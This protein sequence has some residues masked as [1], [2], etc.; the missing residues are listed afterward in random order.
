MVDAC[1]VERDV[2]ETSDDVFD[3]VTGTYTP[4]VGDVAV[5][6]SGKCFVHP[7]SRVEEIRPEGA[8][9]QYRTDYQ[10]RLP[11]TAIGVLP[12]DR[13]IVTVSSDPDL[14]AHTF[15]VSQ[16]YGSTLTV[17]RRLYLEDLQR[18]PAL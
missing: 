13:F 12:G 1:R 14:I 3:P 17:T 7:A 11:S 18:G 10:A 9:E 16:T 6:Y 5:I 8:Q 15:R 4:P 2:H